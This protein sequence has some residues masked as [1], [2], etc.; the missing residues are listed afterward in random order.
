MQ[1]HILQF[2]DTADQ[3]T[4]Q[5][6]TYERFQVMQDAGPHPGKWSPYRLLRFLFPSSP[7]STWTPL[8]PL[9]CNGLYRSSQETNSRATSGCWELLKSFLAKIDGFLVVPPFFR[10][11]SLQQSSTPM[12]RVNSTVLR[13]YF[14]FFGLSQ[15]F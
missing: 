3:T 14:R 5:V 12:Y 4:Y 15:A 2:E 10:H 1:R 9:N 11:G 7:Q 13:K 6:I 8:N